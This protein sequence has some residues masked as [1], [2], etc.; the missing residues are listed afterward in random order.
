M[1][2]VLCFSLPSCDNYVEPELSNL[3]KSRADENSLEICSYYY[4]RGQSI[5]IKLNPEMVNVVLRDYSSDDDIQT[6]EIPH[7]NDLNNFRSLILSQSQLASML[8]EG[9]I[10]TNDI[11][12]L[13]DVTA[14]GVALSHQILVKLKSVE[15]IDKLR[16][17]AAQVGCKV[18]EPITSDK[19]VIPLT[20]TY[21]SGIGSIAA[22]KYLYENG[23]FEYV[24]PCFCIE[25][26]SLYVPSDP[27]FGRQWNLKSAPGI[28]IEP[29]WEQTKGNPV[30][31]LAIMDDGFEMSNLE[32]SSHLFP[33]YYGYEPPQRRT[34]RSLYHGNCVASVATASH[35]NFC[36]SGVAPDVTAMNINIYTMRQDYAEKCIQGIDF[37]QNNG[38]DV[39]NCS[40]GSTES[41]YHV[42]SVE[43]KFNEAAT[44]G[45]NGK[46]IVVV[47]AA[48]NDG[49]NGVACPGKDVSRAI[50]VGATDRNGNI[51]DFSARG[52]EVDVVAPG[53]E[54]LVMNIND[55]VSAS[56]TS[57]AAPHVSGLAALIL[58]VR[59]DLTAAQVKQLIIET[60]SRSS[61][62]NDYGWG[63]INAGYA[64]DALN[65]KFSFVKPFMTA[66]TVYTQAGG[67]FTY[68]L[69]GV[70]R[71]AQTVWK[72]KCG[73]VK[74]SSYN[75]VTIAYPKI[76]RY[77]ETITA[78]V[79]YM[80]KSS[81]YTL[82]CSVMNSDE[83]TDVRAVDIDDRPGYCHLYVECTEENPELE[84]EMLSGNN[85][86]L[87]DFYFSMD[88]E[89]SSTYGHYVTLVYGMGSETPNNGA[90]CRLKV[91]FK[92][93]DQYKIVRVGYNG[94]WG[95]SL[96]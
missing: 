44:K 75:S 80:G 37:A 33:A 26:N 8:E 32:F 69:S 1:L 40:F 57:F 64:F 52:P 84:W 10:G 81:T 53:K 90:S 42:E 92:G 66:N 30:I 74:S 83:I 28:N 85:F 2:C 19:L 15:G 29:V 43:S 41:R 39:I 55:T 77:N 14:D 46:G 89:Y 95:A 56:G 62:S 21:E 68:N 50:R 22:A 34:D 35:N 79:T 47:F 86:S 13:E 87:Q 70:P 65:H 3:V 93:L 76:G 17:L 38:A 6:P 18:W 23:D 67:R 25:M 82:D 73:T 20:T 31:K 11:I 63:L 72:S 7:F 88:A 71:G 60:A 45:R 48:G 49:N 4:Y 16:Q 91:S 5:E 51:C 78:T 24:D 59:P 54:I 27:C 94:G 61:H 36:I 9:T 12:S 58:S 96:E